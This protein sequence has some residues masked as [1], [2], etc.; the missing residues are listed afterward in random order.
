MPLRVA[1]LIFDNLSIRIFCKK[2][3]YLTAKIDT[4][5]CLTGLFLHGTVIYIFIPDIL[6]IFVDL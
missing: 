3:I 6:L 2:S 1:M 5:L 4:L